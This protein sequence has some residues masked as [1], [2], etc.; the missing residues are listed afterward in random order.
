MDKASILNILSTHFNHTSGNHLSDKTDE[1]GFDDWQNKLIKESKTVLAQI[2]KYEKLVSDYI[3]RK[4]SA[5]N[6]IIAKAKQE[7]LQKATEI[8]F[9]SFKAIA[10]DV[11]YNNVE[12]DHTLLK[13]VFNFLYATSDYDSLIATIGIAKAR[14]EKIKNVYSEVGVILAD[15]LVVTFG[16]ARTSAIYLGEN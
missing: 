12:N 15:E 6:P 2:N 10:S 14:R 1:F 4:N 7:M 3:R 9:T 8:V 11:D 16:G 5:N 13:E